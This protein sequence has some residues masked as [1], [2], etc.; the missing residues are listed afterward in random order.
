MAS[1]EWRRGRHR[2]TTDPE[3]MDLD[4]VHGFLTRSYWATG[5][6]R[7]RVERSISGSIP[8]GVFEDE[9]QVGFARV[10][11]DGATF[12]WLADVFVLPEWRGH[13][14]GVWL[15][16]TILA[17]P[18]LQGLRR[19]S[20]ATR[21]AHSLYSRFGFVRVA[22]P[23][24]MMEFRPGSPDAGGSATARAPTQ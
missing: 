22:N 21:D 7:E 2:I 9:Q 16:E 14:L 8:F 13:G 5:V 15:V 6:S 19:W 20:L 12:A 3:A 1:H 4:V 24:R 18:D 17:H 11:S 23:E 10:I